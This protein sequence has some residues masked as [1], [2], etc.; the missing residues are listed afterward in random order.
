MSGRTR[1]PG[2]FADDGRSRKLAHRNA[3]MPKRG[4]DPHFSSLF[5]EP[6][7]YPPLS[8]GAASSWGWYLQWTSGNKLIP[9]TNRHSLSLVLPWL[10]HSRCYIITILRQECVGWQGWG[11]FFFSFLFFFLP[12]S[13]LSVSLLYYKQSSVG[14]PV[15]DSTC[16]FP[17]WSP[18]F[19]KCNKYCGTRCSSRSSTYEQKRTWVT[20]GRAMVKGPPNLASF[21]VPASRPAL[22]SDALLSYSSIVDRPHWGLCHKSGLN[23]MYSKL[24]SKSCVHT[25]VLHMYAVC[26]LCMY[27]A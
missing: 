4:R 26:I 23:A 9:S 6:Q 19:G 18:S 11:R 24:R 14:G 12:P 1:G 27:V 7:N 13:L 25:Y 5:P 2:N 3:G 22:F 21:R 15:L 10:P 8:L 16:T 20:V 17:V